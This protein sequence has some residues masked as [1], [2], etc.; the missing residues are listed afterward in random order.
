MFF[1]SA[2][3]SGIGD[4]IG[5]NVGVGAPLLYEE[6]LVLWARIK[7]PLREA[8]EGKIFPQIS[9]LK[10]SDVSDISDI[11]GSVW[12]SSEISGLDLSLDIAKSPSQLG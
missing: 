1:K 3:K 12:I 6:S 9:H 8:S 5:S 7:W 11:G 10:P 2:N 4:S